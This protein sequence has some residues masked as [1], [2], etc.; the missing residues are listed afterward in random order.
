MTVLLEDRLEAVVRAALREGLFYDDDVNARV[1]EE[2]GVPV[3][4]DLSRA[5]YHAK[6]RIRDEARLA[7][8][9]ALKAAGYEHANALPLH[10]GERY[11][12]VTG[13]VYVGAN[14][15]EYSAP[16]PVRV[17]HFEDRLVL[18]RRGH[19]ARGMRPDG[20]MMLR[21]GWS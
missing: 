21:R 4:R 2:L 16:I 11:T 19:R 7:K 1:S 3:D 8:E 12:L 10:D 15:P 14:V 18:I 6:G 5:V 20:T 17:G 9:D 13:T